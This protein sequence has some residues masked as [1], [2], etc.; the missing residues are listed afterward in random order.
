MAAELLKRGADLVRSGVHP[1]SVIAGY[2]LAA[3]EGVRFINESLSI[4]TADLDG[5]AL[6]SVAATTMASKVVGGADGAAFARI[7]VDALLAVRR[8]GVGGGPPTYPVKGVT[9]L[10]AL[11]GA[12]SDSSL[13][14]GVALT[15]SRCAQGMPTRVARARVACL[16]MNLQKARMHMGVSV[17]VTDPKELEAIRER[18]ATIARDRVK[19]LLDAGANVVLTTKGIDDLCAKYF[20]EAGA[21]AARRVPKD[22][23]KRVARATGAVIVSTLADDAGGETFDPA[24]LGSADEVVEESVA[25][26]DVLVIRSGCGGANGASPAASPRVASADASPPTS[27]GGGSG[28]ATIILRGANDYLLDEMERAVHDA[29]C[30]VRRVLECGAVVP[31]GGAVEAGLSVHLESFAT[32]LGSREQLAIAEAADAVLAVPKA[33]AVNAARDGAD[34]VAKL[35]AYHAAAQ[36]Q[37]GK[38]RLARSGLDLEAGAVRD[39]VEAGVLEPAIAKVNALRFAAEA[40]ITLLRV[41]DLIRVAPTGEEDE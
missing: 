13:V 12:M 23:L 32:S 11:G 14:R 5:D 3:K 40:A 8:D 15:A 34:L 22:D 27:V 26:D 17:V 41:D 36:T 39:S 38:A 29:L 28:G 7:V 10:K 30:A 20:V 9:I 4:P 19:A 25:G 35:R 18:E 31:G 16:D 2:R 21:L 1:T 6:A 24:W 37:P 33:L